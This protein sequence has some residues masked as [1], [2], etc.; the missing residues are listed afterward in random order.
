MTPG[1]LRRAASNLLHP[2]LIW[3]SRDSGDVHASSFQM[4][5]EQNVVRH[6]ASPRQHLDGEEVGSCEHVQAPAD[7]FLPSC[8]LT[9]LGSGCE[10]VAAQDIAHCLVRNLI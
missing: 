1:F 3:M 8:R 10:V 7:E 5:K 6:Q 4:Q 9:P 2:L